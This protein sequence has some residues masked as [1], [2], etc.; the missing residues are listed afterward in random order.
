MLRTNKSTCTASRPLITVGFVLAGLLP[1]SLLAQGGSVW[2][3]NSTSDV[4]AGMVLSNV[5]PPEPPPGAPGP[6]SASCINGHH[7]AGPLH[8]VYLF[9]GEVYQEA[10]DL[11]IPGRGMD[12]VWARKYRSKDGPESA[13]G[14]GWDFSYNIHIQARSQNIL[15]HDGNTR[16]DLF[17]KQPDG[18]YQRDGFFLI[19]EKNQDGSYTFTFQNKGTWNFHPLDGSPLAGRIQ[20]IRDRNGNTISFAYEP[21]TGRLMV[22]TDTLDRDTTLAYDSNGFIQK[23]TDFTGREVRY[24]HYLNGD[25]GGSAGDLA[26]VRSP[27]VVGTPNGNDFPNGKTTTY[28]YSQGFANPRL[29]HNLLTI[30]DPLGQVWLK[31]VYAATTNPAALLF[32][33]LETQTW[34]NPGDDIAVHYKLF[35]GGP[36]AEY[37]AVTNDRVGN[38]HHYRFDR[39]NCLVAVR[40]FTGRADPDLP[41]TLTTNLPTGKLRVTDPDWFDTKFAW[42]KDL[43][44]TNQ[45]L[46]SGSSTEFV[47]ERE[48]N[49]SASRLTLGNLRER[50]RLPGS[51]GGN[52]PELVELF[53]YGADSGN[54]CGADFVTRYTDPSGVVTLHE[55]DPNGNRTRTIYPIAGAE[56]W[57]Y[58]AHGQVTQHRHVPTSTSHVRTD[59]YSYYDASALHQ[60]GWLSQIVRDQGHLDLTSTFAYDIYGNR[61]QSTDAL[62]AE[63]QVIYNQLNQPVSILTREATQGTQDRGESLM[64]YDAKNRLFRTDEK[65]EGEHTT[66]PKWVSTL[67]DYDV[68]GHVTRQSVE[69][70]G[71]ELTAQEYEYDANGSLILHRRPPAVSG[72]DLA[73]VDEH[74]PDERLLPFRVTRAPGTVEQT[75]NESSYDLNGAPAHQVVTSP[76]NTWSDKHRSYDGYGRLIQ[77]LDSL[78]GT[79]V[80]TSYDANNNVTTQTT[81]GQLI[82]DGDTS[83]TVQ[84]DSRFFT[85]DAL[86]RKVQATRAHFELASQVAVD[87]GAITNTTTWSSLGLVQSRT[88]DK[89]GVTQYE[90]DTALRRVA[91]TDPAGNR[92]EVVLDEN[93]RPIE[94]R[95]ISISSITPVPEIRVYQYEYDGRGRKIAWTDPLG[96]Q[97]HWAYN[98]RSQETSSIDKRGN[99]SENFHDA[100]GRLVRTEQVL[101]ASGDG[102]GP[103]VGRIVREF[104]YDVAGRL[105]STTDANGNVTSYAYDASDNR[106]CATRQDSTFDC[107]VYDGPVVTQK[108]DANGTQINYIHSSGLLASRLVQP[109]PGVLGTDEMFEWNGLKHLARGYDND[110]H[111]AFEHDSLG[112]AILESLTINPGPGEVIGVTVASAVGLDDLNQLLYPGGRSLQYE[113]TQ[114]SAGH[115]VQRIIE[116]GFVSGGGSQEHATFSYLGGR[117]EQRQVTLDLQSGATLRSDY[118]FDQ[119]GWL[120]TEVH[121]FGSGGGNTVAMYDHSFD[122][123]GN[124]INILDLLLNRAHSKEFDS[125]DRLV[126]SAAQRFGGLDEIHDYVLDFQGNRQQVVGA[127]GAGLYV[128]DSSIPPGDFQVNQYTATPWDNRT[129]DENGN[130]VSRSN[131][132]GPPLTNTFDQANR[133]VVLDINAGTFKTLRYDVLG[134]VIEEVTTQA[135]VPEPEL[136]RFFYYGKR[137]IEERRGATA[138]PQTVTWVWPDFTGGQGPVSMRDVTGQD[139]A[140]ASSPKIGVVA[141][142]SSTGQVVERYEYRDFGQPLDAATSQE[143]TDSLIGNRFFFRGQQHDLAAEAIV[144]DGIRIEPSVG[145]SLSGKGLA[146]GPRV[147]RGID[148]VDVVMQR[149]LV[150]SNPNGVIDID[151]YIPSITTMRAG[152][153]GG[154]TA[155]WFGTQDFVDSKSIII[156]DD[157][158]IP[159]GLSG[160]VDQGGSLKQSSPSG[161]ISDWID[162]GMHDDFTDSSDS[163][164]TSGSGANGADIQAS[165]WHGIYGGY[166]LYSVWKVAMDDCMASIQSRLESLVAQSQCEAERMC[167][168]EWAAQQAFLCL[169]PIIGSPSVLYSNPGGAYGLPNHP[170]RCEHCC[171]GGGGGTAPDE[172]DE[173]QDPDEPGPNV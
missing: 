30:T 55:Y 118:L 80:Q 51:L 133:A 74:E 49:P 123:G 62:G 45:T 1:S 115:Q 162:G 93:S 61:T 73:C 150:G 82:V 142:V 43:L 35:S 155:S 105:E 71:T 117:L 69:E 130:L 170:H 168:G 12:F 95:V 173:P 34:G 99:T 101:T 24:T 3:G 154:S 72:L 36:E 143:L 112:N 126:H 166:T 67:T 167:Y 60:E 125:A 47:Y 106:T 21:L 137:L 100:L 23:V 17:R 141:A 152:S 50:R 94:R 107:W 121:E 145:R 87:D 25:T 75:V 140:L 122:D 40:Q 172:P 18:T 131:I 83:D 163:W 10:T 127:P 76:Q 103:E 58:N 11:R 26:S 13:M 38:V 42:N 135:G 171:L 111:L 15:L 109:G 156:E 91:R 164:R 85:Y 29:N 41:T 7:R 14:K 102:N 169:M 89:G 114:T 119:R 79:V 5:E 158:Q 157:L 97:R 68:L 20:S 16:R 128:M 149:E 160:G 53:E 81:S 39:N 146:A 46:P 54:C 19:G 90:Y 65:W 151:G 139:F 44:C 37:L 32:D 27:T 48:Q 86:N 161:S 144:A 78:T 66:T 9:S 59:V 129:Y 57:D 88:D 56:E 2:L 4:P 116:T 31:N 64:W 153:K 138:P 132:F 113:S 33:R 6:Y 147:S 108:M 77:N 70:A 159:L 22:V 110:S 98:S 8:S 134:R 136:V 124:H 96:A 165:L 120:D 63:R 92:E 52:Q 104:A 148:V 28:T 84:L